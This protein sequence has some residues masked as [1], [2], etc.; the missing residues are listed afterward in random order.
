MDQRTPP[1][2]AVPRLLYTVRRTPHRNAEPLFSVWT[3]PGYLCFDGDLCTYS[4]AIVRR[5]VLDELANGDS[6]EAS[7]VVV[8]LAW[9]R[10]IDSA[11]VRL[12]HELAERLALEGRRLTLHDPGPMV[13]RVLAIAGSYLSTDREATRHL[14]DP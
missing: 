13:R 1:P 7:E 2:V 3:T 12:L 8:D 5:H 9:L 4:A 11:G 14:V 10:F 6:A